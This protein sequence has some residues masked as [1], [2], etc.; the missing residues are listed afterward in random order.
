MI[1]EH[2]RVWKKGKNKVDNQ[3]PDQKTR[4]CMRRDLHHKRDGCSRKG[5]ASFKDMC[6]DLADDDGD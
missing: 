5:V 1:K 6:V 3:S 2:R 4:D